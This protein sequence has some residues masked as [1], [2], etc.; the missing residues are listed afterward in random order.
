MRII[1]I[2]TKLPPMKGGMEIHIKQL[3]LYQIQTGHDVTVAFN[4][5]NRISERDIQILRR[6]PIY[7]IK[8]QSIGV[9][10]FYFLL[11]IR[12]IF[13]PQKFDVI[14]IHGD[15]SSLVFAKILKQITKAKIMIYSCHDTLKP[16]SIRLIPFFKI[17]VDLLFSTGHESKEILES[18]LKKEVFYQPSGVKDIF[19]TKSTIE[20]NYKSNQIITV[21]NLVKK[22]N[23]NLTLSIAKILSNYHFLIIGE[24]TEREH[25]EQRLK[26]EK[27][28]NVILAGNKDETYILEQLTHS[29]LFL[30]TSFEEGTSTAMMEAMTTGLPVV[31]SSAGGSNAIVTV[32]ENGYVVTSFEVLEYVEKIKL[33]AENAELWNSIRLNNL[34]K[35]INLS[36]KNVGKNITEKCES[37]KL[38]LH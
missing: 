3:S 31:V 1:R 33:L 17:S 5:G 26:D 2:Y 37:Y 6:I 30:Q 9:I 35:G 10:L 7:K 21:S 29:F 8:P 13:K 38:S 16:I 22:K 24:G 27:I 20:I 18:I 25:L 12:L 23:L 36:W 14:H 19:Y 11:C 34:Q 32:G 28:S 15:W 4:A